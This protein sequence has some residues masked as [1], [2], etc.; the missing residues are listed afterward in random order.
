MSELQY[1]SESPVA[2]HQLAEQYGG[3]PIEDWG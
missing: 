1:L 3:F 2:M